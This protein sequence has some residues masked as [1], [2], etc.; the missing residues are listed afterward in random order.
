M[1][2]A[3]KSMFLLGEFWRL[4]KYYISMFLVMKCCMSEIWR[5]EPLERSIWPSCWRRASEMFCDWIVV[6]GFLTFPSAPLV[7]SS[8]SF[9]RAPL[10]P[11]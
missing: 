3:Y 5:C 8:V 9:L 7:L 1:L 10:R 4:V 2:L 11:G 6:E